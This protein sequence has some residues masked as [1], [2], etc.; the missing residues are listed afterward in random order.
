MHF[1]PLP[2]L[3]LLAAAA[4]ALLLTLG[5]WQLERADWKAGLIAE[6][7]ARAGFPPVDLSA[8]FCG[9]QAAPGQRIEDRAIAYS[10][11][12]VSVY[13]VNEQGRPG[14]RLFTPVALPGCA[15]AG[16]VLAEVG[17][18]PLGEAEDLVIREGEPFR[19]ARPQRSGRFTPESEPGEGR[20]YAYDNEAMAATLPDGVE[21]LSPDWWIVAGPDAA[22]AHLTEVPPARHI[23]YAITWFGFALALIAVYAAFHAARGRL[24]FTRKQD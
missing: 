8:A 3:S 5:V 19:L 10:P 22:P 7:E 21:R 16:H 11:A 17:F 12:F 14:W 9:D 2:L 4:L 23:G 20:F 18:D 13:G 1:R 24:A 15:T 6:Y